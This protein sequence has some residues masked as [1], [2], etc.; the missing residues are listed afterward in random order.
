MTREYERDE[1]GQFAS[2]GAGA[3][4]PA[5]DTPVKTSDTRAEQPATSV[6]V[7]FF[8]RG[9][10]PNSD[11]MARTAKEEE[12]GPSNTPLSAEERKAAFEKLGRV[13]RSGAKNVDLGGHL[14]PELT[15]EG[16]TALGYRSRPENQPLKVF[17]FH[18][19]GK[20]KVEEVPLDDVYRA[21]SHLPLGGITKYVR[22]L[23]RTRPS[24]MRDLS[25]KLHVMSGHTRLAAMKLAGRQKA[26][27]NVFQEKP[28]RGKRR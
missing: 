15:P 22:N 2:T 17:A 21:Q 8:A 3:K 18:G 26:V 12:T 16:M 23:P 14:G 20:P 27:V 28:K 7:P 11:E 6:P 4:G 9:G 19:H 25:G 5:G 13:V 10:I 1:K 24:V